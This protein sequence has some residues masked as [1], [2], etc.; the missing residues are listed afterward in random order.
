MELC[1]V[2]AQNSDDE[3]GCGIACQAV[4][5]TVKPWKEL[6]KQIFVDLCGVLFDGMCHLLLLK[7][8]CLINNRKFQNPRGF[9][10]SNCKLNYVGS[11]GK[12]FGF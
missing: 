12:L 5:K 4:H 7:C 11:R 8:W 6:M 9:S 10:K 2:Q 3:N 1:C